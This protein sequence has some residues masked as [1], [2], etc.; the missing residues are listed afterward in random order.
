M[1]DNIDSELYGLARA[2]NMEDV[3]FEDVYVFQNRIMQLED[4]VKNACGIEE[5]ASI[6]MNYEL[7]KEHQKVLCFV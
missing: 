6:Q 5:L 3:I 1:R 2:S 7:T 4:N